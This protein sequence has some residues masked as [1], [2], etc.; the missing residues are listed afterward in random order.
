MTPSQN[1]VEMASNRPA[2]AHEGALIRGSYGIGH[3]AAALSQWKEVR[4]SEQMVQGKACG[5]VSGV[6]RRRRHTGIEVIYQVL[7]GILIPRAIL[8]FGKH[9]QTNY[10]MAGKPFRV[11]QDRLGWII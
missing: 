11:S 8:P 5:D 4:N 1:L 6:S 2:S 10:N 7:P 3:A 9:S